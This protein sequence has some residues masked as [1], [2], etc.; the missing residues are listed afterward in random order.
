MLEGEMDEHLGY[1]TYERA[2]TINSING[3]K[4]FEANMGR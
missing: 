2:E 3:K 1:E 4:G